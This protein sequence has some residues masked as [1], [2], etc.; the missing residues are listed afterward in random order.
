M[1]VGVALG[2]LVLL[3]VGYVDAGVQQRGPYMWALDLLHKL[4]DH[5]LFPPLAFVLGLVPVFLAWAAIAFPLRRLL[6]LPRRTETATAYL[7]RLRAMEARPRRD[8]ERRAF[9]RSQGRIGLLIAGTL[10]AIWV[11]MWAVTGS[12]FGF[13]PLVGGVGLVAAIVQI[14]TGSPLGR[15]R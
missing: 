6:K 11:G 3:Y 5:Y 14:V 13:L 2:C 15:R 12:F 7:L 4:D 1:F 9:Y 10:L 8:P